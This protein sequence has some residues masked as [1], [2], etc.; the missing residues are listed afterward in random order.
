VAEVKDIFVFA[1]VG[2]KLR[3]ANA[4]GE[5][6]SKGSRNSLVKREG[7]SLMGRMK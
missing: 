7:R 2:T 6:E 4:H 1:D 3:L 5:R